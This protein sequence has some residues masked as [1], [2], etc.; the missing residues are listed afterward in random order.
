MKKCLWVLILLTIWILPAAVMAD[1]SQ[2]TKEETLDE[3]VVTASRS[4]EAKQEISASITIISQEE[5]RQSTARDLGEL[6]FK[7]GNVWIRQYPGALTPVG[8][9]GFKTDTHGNDLLGKV[10]LLLNGRRAGTGNLAKIRTQNIERIEILRGPASVQYGSAGMGGVINVISKR[11]KD[12]PE[13]FVEAGIGSYDRK[14]VSLGGAG[15][16]SG[17]DISGAYSYSESGDYQTSD[18]TTY[19]NTGIGSEESGSV[20]LGYNFNQN[21][22]IGLVYNFYKG[23][24]IGYPG[25]ISSIYADD[26]DYKDSKNDS[27]DLIYEGGVADGSFSWMT[28][29][30][31][32]KD[33]DTW[34]TVD[35][36]YPSTYEIETD[37]QGAQGQVTWDS[38]ILSLTGGIDWLDY[39]YETSGTPSDSTYDNTAGFLMAKLGFLDRRL[40]FNGGLRYDDYEVEIGNNEGGSQN[41]D[42]FVGNLGI[43]FQATEIIKLRAAWGQGF[44]MP[45]A[46]QL[47][48]DYTSWSKTYVGNPDLD[49]ESSDTFEGGVDVGIGSLNVSVTYFH[50]DYE[51]FIETVATSTADTY[52][53]DN[54]DNGTINGFEW[55]FS[56]DMGKYFV[57]KYTVKPYFKGTYFTT[58]EDDSDGSDLTYIPE[59]TINYGLT[60]GQPGNFTANLNFAYYGDENVYDWNTY[61]DTV[62]TGGTLVDFSIMHTIAR[63]GDYGN[64]SVKGEIMNLFDED[65]EYVLDYP[66]AGRTFYLGMRWE[67]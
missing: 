58:Y 23:D 6:L 4:R 48:G 41:T 27:A 36:S 5:I 1:E 57:W 31:T 63:I 29:Y 64:I 65:V 50:T 18:G 60:V 56:W 30:F 24:E 15:K 54:V 20:N 3:M 19:T 34:V 67:Y 25:G 26:D 8:V 33:K 9:R 49:P 59:S 37:Q 53:Y 13:A 17:F 42:N 16:V 28:R 39:D 45:G 35:P 52:T 61:T 40:I 10:L 51:D 43:A 12:K 46:S 55:E 11:G 66:Q 14:E 2:D 21:N 47:A 62:K 7:T 32:G 22:R 44:V 38:E